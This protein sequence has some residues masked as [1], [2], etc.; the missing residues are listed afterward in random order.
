[1]WACSGGPTTTYLRVH[2][3]SLQP[4][5]PI[6]AR[7]TPRGVPF[8][9]APSSSSSCD[10]CHDQDGAA[11][12]AFDLIQTMAS[13][14]TSGAANT[15]ATTNA[16]SDRLQRPDARDYLA[17]LRACA[18]AGDGDCAGSPSLALRLL[19]DLKVLV[20]AAR[21]VDEAETGTPLQ[22]PMGQG[23]AFLRD[24]DRE[25]GRLLPEHYRAAMAACGRGGDT[26]GILDLLSELRQ[27]SDVTQVTGPAAGLRLPPSEIATSDES[28]E[29]RGPKG[30]LLDDSGD[31]DEAGRAGKA[32]RAA[33]AAGVVPPLSP[34]RC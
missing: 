34:V 33:L 28:A 10:S 2:P 15:A 1:M 18:G 26:Q 27:A 9:A 7:L 17:A 11:K 14:S 16:G 8:F 19:T 6:P 32:T 24:S 25:V 13:A 3:L 20:V 31:G 4:T 21:A 5:P 22:S 12:T 23:S 29:G 30:G